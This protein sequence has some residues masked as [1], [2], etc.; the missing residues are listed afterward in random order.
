MKVSAKLQKAFN[1]YN[2]RAKANQVKPI[3]ES[4]LA[5]FALLESITKVVPNTLGEFADTW[6]RSKATAR[7]Q[8]AYATVND[9]N[10]DKARAWVIAVDIFDYCE[11]RSANPR[12]ENSLR[13]AIGSYYL[14]ELNNKCFTV[15]PNRVN[16]HSAFIVRT[17]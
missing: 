8:T 14:L 9:K 2:E 13:E 10:Y 6:D 7:F 3:S 12:M 1:A 16:S 4:R 5:L 15:V 11:T 17:Q